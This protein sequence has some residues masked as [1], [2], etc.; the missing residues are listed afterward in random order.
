[1]FR[2][3]EKGFVSK[4]LEV[5]TSSI[6]GAG[7]GVFTNEDIGRHELV[8]VCPAIIFEY[9]IFAMFAQEMEA[10]HILTDYIFKWPNGQTSVILG[11]GMMYNHSSNAN[12]TWKYR[13]HPPHA[14]EFWSKKPISAGEELFINYGTKNE[15]GSE[16]Q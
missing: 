11:N 6:A 1:M 15:F 14:V 9:S 7:L 13:E 16:N 12:L 4:S 2:E 10:Q 5:K 3:K 8:E